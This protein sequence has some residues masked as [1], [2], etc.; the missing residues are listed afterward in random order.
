MDSDKRVASCN[1][2]VF[3]I[4]GIVSLIMYR[5]ARSVMSLMIVYERED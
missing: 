3:I 4:I 2:F 5:P 1:P